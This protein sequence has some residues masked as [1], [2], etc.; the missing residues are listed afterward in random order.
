MRVTAVTQQVLTLNDDDCAQIIASLLSVITCPLRHALLLP[1]LRALHAVVASSPAASSRHLQA[2]HAALKPYTLVTPNSA[3]ASVRFAG[4]DTAAHDAPCALTVHVQA[5][6]VLG[7]GCSK[8]GSHLLEHVVPLATAFCANA[9][10][11]VGLSAHVSQSSSARG[12]DGAA[13]AAAAVAS[14]GGVRVAEDGCRELEM[15]LAS[16]TWALQALL[17]ECVTSSEVTSQAVVC[18]RACVR[19]CVS[20]CICVRCGAR[21]RSICCAAWCTRCVPS[22]CPSHPAIS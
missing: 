12:D 17:A 19:A 7:S 14:N 5:V 13:A 8:A 21:V 16:N 18:A 1:A 2:M 22:L 20:L 3:G 6:N 10:M 9:H 4:E 11:C 15:V